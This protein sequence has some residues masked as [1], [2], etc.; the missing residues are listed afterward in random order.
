M[1]EI[2]NENFGNSTKK[3]QKITC[4]TFTGNM[5]C[6]I[7]EFFYKVLSKIAQRKRL[8]NKPPILFEAEEILSICQ[9][10]KKKKRENVRNA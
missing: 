6:L 2:K 4:K 7:R 5:F 10:T 8:K 3:L 1:L 9:L